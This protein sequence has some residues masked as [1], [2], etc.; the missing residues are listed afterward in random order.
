[1]IHKIRKLVHIL[2]K[3]A[4]D[5]DKQIVENL[6]AT[7][8]WTHRWQVRGHWRRVTGIGKN[9]AGEYVVSG[10]TY[11]SEYEK[12]PEDAPL[13]KK[14]RLFEFNPSGA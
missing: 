9:R 6:A 12:G 13:I 5:S 8:D 7:I 1:M 4:T 3:N 14:T 11:V 10:Y 2:P